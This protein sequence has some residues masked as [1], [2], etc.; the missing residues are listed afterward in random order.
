M[1]RRHDMPFGAEC[2]SDG[3]VRFRLWAPAARRVELCLG[4]AKGPMRIPLDRRDNGWFE[5]VTNAAGAGTKYKF[6]I[7]NEREVPDPASRFQPQDVH[8][9]SEVIDPDVFDWQDLAWRGRPWEEAVIYELHVGA[10]T[11]RAAGAH[12]RKRTLPSRR[13]SAPNGMS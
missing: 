6:R 4:S 10:F 1:K 9:P 13:H 3:S 11:P 5:L 12:R 8:G 2:R 7:D